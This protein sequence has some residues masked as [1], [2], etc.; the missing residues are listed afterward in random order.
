MVIR[1]P[2]AD[3]G[4]EDFGYK[5]SLD[6]SIGKFASFAAGVS[7]ISILAGTFQRRRMTSRSLTSRRAFLPLMVKGRPLT[8][9]TPGT[10]TP[11]PTGERGAESV[12][13]GS[14]TAVRAVLCCAA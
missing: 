3:S 12:T 2:H 9:P 14:A 7:Y 11:S 13:S 10:G 8:V 1:E 5:E 6:R 4:M